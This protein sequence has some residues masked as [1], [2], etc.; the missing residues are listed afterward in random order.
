M[1][2]RGSVCLILCIVLSPSVYA[3]SLDPSE[4]PIRR[5]ILLSGP[6][7]LSDYQLR[8]LLD[9]K[10]LI[11]G[12][13][14]RPDCGDVRFAD[15]DK[16]SVLS[17][18]LESGCNTNNTLFWVNVP[19]IVPEKKIYLYYGIPSMESESSGERTF[20]FYEG[21]DDTFDQSGWHQ[22]SCV[23][24]SGGYAHLFSLNGT[25]SIKSTKI[26]PS[27]GVL[28]LKARRGEWE[29]GSGPGLMVSYNDASSAFEL[30]A[31]PKEGRWLLHSSKPSPTGVYGESIDQ[32]EHI[33][34]IAYDASG[35][36]YYFFVDSSLIAKNRAFAPGELSS[37]NIFSGSIPL[38]YLVSDSYYDYIFIRKYTDPE[39]S[40][41]MRNETALSIASIP[42][43][44]LPEKPVSSGQPATGETTMQPA[45]DVSTTLSA[46]SPSQSEKSKSPS[47]EKNDP[48]ISTQESQDTS[49]QGIITLL[50][51]TV[52]VILS[53][54]LIYAVY[55]KKKSE[56]LKE[57]KE[58]LKWITDQ[59][60]AGAD[61]EDIKKAANSSGVDP[62]LVDKARD[63][64]K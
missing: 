19:I 63:M 28:H 9:T 43:G 22:Q 3:S 6:K 44:T 26:M 27:S 33:F 7:A 54:L 25:C 21:F 34:R 13:K 15:S 10:S 41:I 2:T 37:L 18:Y 60:L 35:K 57:N 29:T 1:Q 55:L 39:P 50:P 40:L 4:W 12:G 11:D 46:P 30:G 24:V 14:M 62:L 64:L 56:S 58:V 48:K 59:L 5:E 61:P 51:I 23:S 36:I 49:L 38:G 52:F 47:E 8:V 17:Y 31:D 20:Q 53:I 32:K 16:F 42:A 45:T